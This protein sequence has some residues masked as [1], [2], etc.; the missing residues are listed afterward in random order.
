M[1]YRCPICGNTNP[2]YI[3]Y[4]KNTPYCRRCLKFI[5]KQ[6]V[7]NIT[8][9]NETV[10]NLNYELTQKQEAISNQIIDN[11][12]VKRNTLIHAVC[13]AGKT[14]LTFKLIEYCL[15]NNLKVG[16][17]IPRK[18]VVIELYNRLKDVFINSKVICLYGGNTNDL[19]GELTVLT[20]HQ[21]YR[22][23]KYFDLLILDEIDAFPFKNNIVLHSFLNR[24]LKG[25]LLLMT[26]TISDYEK[27]T[28]RNNKFEIIELYQRFHGYKIPVPKI[29][30]KTGIFKLLYLL[31]KVKEFV[32]NKK[33]LLIF[34][35]YIKDSINLFTFINIFVKGG[36]YLN[37]K[38]EKRENI[39]NE[40]K[41]GELKY[42]VTTSVLERG[43]TLSNL[44]V[45][46]YDSYKNV[47]DSQTLIQISG[48]VG[49][50]K[51]FPNGE[52]I[53]LSYKKTKE[54]ENAIKTIIEENNIRG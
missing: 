15:K 9:N 8:F 42:I 45:I 43:V 53:F 31:K 54:M 36:A 7:E 37:S 33:P 32:D 41:R 26:A 52:I 40:F 20:T 16:F 22:Y 47:F 44:Q 23:K 21:L 50:K 1:S 38:V 5:A 48:R 2:I 17:S 14:E 4:F 6:E 35:G 51:E 25:N 19:E 10:L 34:V 30:L 11:F 12:K 39:I 27:E 49:R 46:V 28:F 24:S 13:G 18:D 3:G 29:V